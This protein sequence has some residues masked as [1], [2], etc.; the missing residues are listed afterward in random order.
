MADQGQVIQLFQNLIGNAIKYQSGGTPLIRIRAERRGSEW[1]FS[2]EDNGIG[3]EPKHYEKIF[4][5]FQRLHGRGQYSGTGIGLALC[6]KIVE[7][8]GGR[9]WVESEPGKGSTFFFTLP[10]V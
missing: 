7:R 9:I 3:I 10:G 4:L 8:H 1:V 5:I 2:V 6:K